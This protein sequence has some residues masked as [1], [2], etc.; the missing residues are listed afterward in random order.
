MKKLMVKIELFWKHFLK[1]KK[2][3]VVECDWNLWYV[4][5]NLQEAVKMVN[6]YSGKSSGH[7]SNILWFSEGKDTRIPAAL[8]KNEKHKY[9]NRFALSR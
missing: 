1:K 6:G 9:L 2:S 5:E 8:D 3:Q 7:I 4:Y